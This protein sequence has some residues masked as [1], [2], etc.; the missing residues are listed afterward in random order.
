MEKTTYIKLQKPIIFELVNGN[1]L[2][3][4]YKLKKNNINLFVDS[5]TTDLFPKETNS[6][7]V[8]K[9]IEE[10]SLDSINALIKNKFETNPDVFLNKSKK[11]TRLKHGKLSK[12]DSVRVDEFLFEDFKIK[13]N[14]LLINK[15]TAIK[16]IKEDRQKK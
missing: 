13:N 4:S 10:E 9:T 11:D 15:E 12:V 6:P 8:I 7:Q 3:Y 16:F 5:S 1:P 2:K 14:Q